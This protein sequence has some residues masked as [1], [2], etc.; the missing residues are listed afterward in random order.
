MIWF[1]IMECCWSLLT[2]NKT[3]FDI[4]GADHSP[5]I[6]HSL[7]TKALSPYVGRHSK[8]TGIS[9]RHVCNGSSKFQGDSLQTVKEVAY[10]NLLSYI[11]YNPKLCK[12]E[13]NIIC[14]NKHYFFVSRAHAHVNDSQ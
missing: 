4:L 9:S 2:H 6:R 11:R 7:K 14:Q 12:Q 10:T 5:V 13:K 1:L 3:F 8:R